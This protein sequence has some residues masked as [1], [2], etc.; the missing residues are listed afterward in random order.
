MPTF[1]L[2]PGEPFKLFDN[3]AGAAPLNGVAVA[4]PTTL[5]KVLT[6][7]YSFA[8]APSAVSIKVQHSV[9]GV[10]F[11]DL[12]TGTA[13]GGETRTT[14]V[15]DAVFIRGRRESQTGGGNVTLSIVFGY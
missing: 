9:D 10:I 4:V 12:D 15:N 1:L 14:A 11:T 7:T 5:A 8:S 3:E 6:W 13:T 2:Q